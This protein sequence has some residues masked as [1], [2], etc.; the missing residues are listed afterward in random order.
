MKAPFTE[1]DYNKLLVSEDKDL[2]IMKTL[3]NYG[4]I[5]W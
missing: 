3:I 5:S 4:I 2:K 1:F